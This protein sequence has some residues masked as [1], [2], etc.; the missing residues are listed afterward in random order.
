MTYIERICWLTLGLAAIGAMCAVLVVQQD[1]IERLTYTQLALTQDYK[2]LSDDIQAVRRECTEA[3][4]DHDTILAQMDLVVAAS[5]S[6]WDDAHRLIRAGVL[7]I[8]SQ[9]RGQ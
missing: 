5:R 2:E 1:A 8:E 4:A 3:A 9:E 7:G 6:G